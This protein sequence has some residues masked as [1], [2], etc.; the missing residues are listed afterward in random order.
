MYVVAQLHLVTTPAPVASH[1][2]KLAACNSNT[3]LQDRTVA[4]N[5]PVDTLHELQLTY[6]FDN[7]SS[8]SNH[9]NNNNYYY[10]NK[11]KTVQC[12]L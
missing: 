4:A 5:Q 12:H 3:K 1:K 2:L 8:K 6:N 10:Y 11:K 9:H 7:R